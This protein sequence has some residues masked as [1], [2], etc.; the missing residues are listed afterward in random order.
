MVR[1]LCGC[2]GRACL[3]RTLAQLDETAQQ[4]DRT[5][6]QRGR[7][8]RSVSAEERR[9]VISHNL[10][11]VGRGGVG[12]P[13]EFH[14]AEGVAA[15]RGAEGGEEVGLGVEPIT[16]EGGGE[17]S[18]RRCQGFRRIHARR[19]VR[20]LGLCDVCGRCKEQ[21]SERCLI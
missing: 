5:T 11:V 21:R 17:E 9:A 19:R 3:A 2:E 12:A 6:Q 16:R 10:G 15:A 20:R 8:A 4:L 7:L 1:R 14:S 18:L 13:E